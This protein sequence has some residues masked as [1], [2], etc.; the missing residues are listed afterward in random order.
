M[1]KLSEKD[2]PLYLE[3][4]LGVVAIDMTGKVAY[5][6]N[7]CAGYFAMEKE[8]IIGKHILDVFPGSKMIEGLSKDKSGIEFYNTNLGIGITIQVPLFKENEKV[9]LLE[10]DATQDSEF[11][12]DL[13][14]GYS[15]FLDFELKNL[16]KQITKLEGTKYSIHNIAG[17]SPATLKLK[18]DIIS[19]AKTNSTVIITGETGTGKEM[20]AHAIHNLSNRRKSRMV[21]INAAAFPENLVESE[22]FGYDKG[23]FTGAIKEGKQGKFEQANKGT[24]FID[25]IN[26]MPLSVQPKLLRVLQEKEIDR[27]GSNKSVPV[28]VRII[29]AT[30]QKLKDMVKMG[31]FREDLFYRFNVIEIMIP[32]LRERLDD[33]E[34]MAASIIDDLN[35]ELGLS[36]MGLEKSALENLKKYNWPGNVR[37]LR[38]ILERAMNHTVGPLLIDQDFTLE[39]TV[40]CVNLI[41]YVEENITDSPIDLVKN[42]A[43]RD[44]IISALEKF[45]YNKSKTA[46]YLR[47]AR[48]LLYQ[49]IKRLN[50]VPNNNK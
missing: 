21:K 32:P 28:D 35:G 14:D 4:V 36:I 47:I 7:Q 9:G 49:K 38:N 5:V 16:K 6:N 2:I 48:P 30:N 15:R 25:E 40:E 45:N 22:L 41:K 11:L 23:A 10:Y 17:S 3:S 1:Y 50:I 12:Y 20:V 34:E 18:E 8:A 19:A 42:K 26:Q 31:T 29:A 24:L 13:S 46:E 27:I 33:L 44:L 39:K 37:E 43:E